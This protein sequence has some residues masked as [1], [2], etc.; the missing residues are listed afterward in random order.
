MRGE[1]RSA[2]VV[3]DL[4]GKPEG[5]KLAGPS[6]HL[7]ADHDECIAVHSVVIGQQDGVE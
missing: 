5:E 3:I 1:A 6:R 7:E 4:V 2:G